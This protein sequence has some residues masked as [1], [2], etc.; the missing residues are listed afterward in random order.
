MTPCA[1]GG[2]APGCAWPGRPPP[3]G[4]GSLRALDIDFLKPGRRRRRRL[5]PSN[6]RRGRG[7]PG[8]PTGRRCGPEVPAPARPDPVPT[9]PG[10]AHRVHDALGP[11]DA[12]SADRRQRQRQRRRDVELGESISQ[13]SRSGGGAPLG[14]VRCA[15][16]SD[17]AQGRWRRRRRPSRSPPGP[18]GSIGILARVPHASAAHGRRL[19]TAHRSPM[20]NY[21][22]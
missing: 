5:A 11:A 7:R 4:P 8:A 15:A 20:A 18:P 6:R 2:G 21:L 10:P 3:T 9:R 13:L 1:A 14:A 12:R 16:A 19:A 22:Y 17:A